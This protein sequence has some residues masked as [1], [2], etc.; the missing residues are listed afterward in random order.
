MGTFHAQPSGMDYHDADMGNFGMEDLNPDYH[1]MGI[2][3]N[4]MVYSDTIPIGG[5]SGDPGWTYPWEDSPANSVYVQKELPLEF[6]W[7]D[8][9]SVE[10]WIFAIATLITLTIVVAL[11]RRKRR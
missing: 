7:K 1:Y 6:S 5:R 11:L 9:F 8:I 4:G 2:Y 3:D 10:K